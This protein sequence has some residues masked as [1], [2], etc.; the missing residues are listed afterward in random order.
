MTTGSLTWRFWRAYHDGRFAGAGGGPRGRWN[1]TASRGM[2]RVSP[3]AEHRGMP[4][5][6]ESFVAFYKA[7]HTRLLKQVYAITTDLGEAED[8][9]QEAFT[10]AA[11]RWS[12]IRTYASPEAWVR[13]VA[14][15]LAL[16]SLRRV[17]RHARALLRLGPPPPVPPLSTDS[18]QV[19]E[20][21]RELPVRQRQVVVLYYLVDLPVDQVAAEL[22]I[23]PGTVKTRLMRARKQLTA[24]LHERPDQEGVV[25]NG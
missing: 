24:R 12:T 7:S 5:A 23:P 10:R 17:R 4:V 3:T 9:L 14:F 2:Y 13:R 25:V 8:V 1:R 20:A 11:M 18:L 21:L 15:N 16:Q 22:G 19:H 6:D